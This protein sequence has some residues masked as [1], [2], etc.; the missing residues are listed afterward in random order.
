[1]RKILV[2]VVTLLTLCIGDNYAQLTV[3]IGKAENVNPNTNVTIDVTTTGFTNLIGVQLSINFDSLVLEYVNSTNFAAGIGLTAQAISGPNGVGV[4]NGQMTFSWFDN[5]GTGKSLPAGARLFSIV[6]KAKGADCSSTDIFT[7]NVPRAVEITDSDVKSVALNNVKGSVKMRC[8]GGNP[9]PCPDP[10]CSNANNLAIIGGKVNGATGSNVC[11]PFTVKNF[12]AIQSGQ[13]TFSWNPSE[14]QYINRVL[15]FPGS[16]DTTGFTFNATNTANGVLGFLWSNP[17]PGA[18]VTLPNNTKLIDLC[19]KVLAGTPD[20]VCVLYGSNTTV[21]VDWSNDN[22]EVPTCIQYGKVQIGSTPQD[23]VNLILGNATGTSGQTVCVDVTVNNFEDILGL[24]ANF[25]WDKN[26]LQFVRTDMYM[27][28]GLNANFHFKDSI[29]L[30]KL[31]W[32]NNNPVDRA[33]GSKIFQICFQIL[34]PCP[35]SAPIRILKNEVT[36]LVNNEAVEVPSSTT[37]GMISCTGSV[38]MPVITCTPGGVTNVTCNGLTNGSAPLS[39]SGTLLNQCEIQ[40]SSNGNIVKPYAPISSGTNLTNVG[41]GIYMYSVRWTVD[42]SITLCSGNVTINQPQPINIPTSNVIT[43][44]SCNNKG[45][46]DLRLVSGGTPL[47]SNPPYNFSWNPNLGNT[48]N[49]TNLDPGTYSVTV[50]DAN[51]CSDSE[52]FTLTENNVPLSPSVS[53]T[54]VKCNGESN[55]AIMVNVTGGCAPYTFSPANLTNLA[56]GSYIIT[57]TDSKNNTATVN[58]TITQP[59]PLLIATPV[60]TDATLPNNNNGAIAITISGGT[61]LYTVSWSGGLAGGTTNSTFNTS[62]VVPGSYSATVTDVKGC[63]ATVTNVQVKGE[64]TTDTAPKIGSITASTS[65]G[66][67]GVKCFGES[68]GSITLNFTGSLPIKAQ[69]KKNNQNEGSEQ[70]INSGNSYTFSNLGA[71]NYTVVLTNSAGTET[72]S[73]VPVTQPS[74]LAPSATTDCTEISGSTGSA[75]INGNNTGVAPYTYLWS[76]NNATTQSISSLARGV[77][78]VTVTD[79]NGCTAILSNI[80]VKNCGQIGGC[81]EATKIITPNGDNFN[82]LFVINCADQSNNDLVIFDRFGNTVYSQIDYDNTWSG[83]DRG[84]KDLDE[85]VYYWVFTSKSSL[86]KREVYKGSVTILRNR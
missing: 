46:I 70:N 54:N 21:P 38:D 79:D 61:P 34:G 83:V 75:T 50:T 66:G 47:S 85:G 19:F 67:F 52:T 10:A 23:V 39:I 45:S 30:L 42:N 14:L 77:Y 8:G 27:L 12:N 18:P 25:S 22:G 57:V 86:G 53:V 59:D 72:S 81:Y 28:D 69:L 13:G 68:N 49:P 37:N 41:A 15:P 31:S 74:K 84:G 40:W 7:S 51:Q 71:G 5:D 26:Q 11:V 16:L 36:A 3:T 24:E 1:M 6:F 20:T 35:S 82:D 56:A 62:N 43:Q 2:F 76:V 60:V 80:E 65:F 64:S 32:S 73:V 63:M 48:N 17:N 4:K 58:A 9:D 78:N 33:D 55:G 29:G 44:P